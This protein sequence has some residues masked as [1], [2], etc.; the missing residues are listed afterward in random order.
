MKRQFGLNPKFQS[1]TEKPPAIQYD[2]D[3][4]PHVHDYDMIMD[5]GR[6]EF[7][8]TLVCG[9]CGDVAPSMDEALRRTERSKAISLRPV[10]GVSVFVMGL[11]LFLIAIGS[12]LWD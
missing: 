1:L 4:G 3:A 9:I 12:L 8:Y 6:D 2:P 5:R 7:S 10:I 11:T